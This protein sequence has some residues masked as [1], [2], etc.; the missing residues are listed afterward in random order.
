M[1]EEERK[2]IQLVDPLYEPVIMYPIGRLPFC[3][4]CLVEY[5]ANYMNFKIKHNEEE[6]SSDHYQKT[7]RDYVRKKVKGELETKLK[8]YPWVLEKIDFNR[9]L[10]RQL[11][12]GLFGRLQDEMSNNLVDERMSIPKIA[13]QIKPLGKEEI[14]K[15]LERESK[16][17]TRCINYKY[18]ED[19]VCE[20]PLRLKGEDYTYSFNPDTALKELYD[21]Y[22]ELINTF[23]MQRLMHLQMTGFLSLKYP[24]ST[25]TRF[26]HV[27][28]TWISGLIALQNVT[29]VT[30][31]GEK[32]LIE[33]LVD[34]DMHR[35]FMAA[36][37]LH[38]IGHA[39]FSHV[40][41]MNP[42]LRYNH[43][44]ITEEEIK[45]ANSYLELEDLL[46][47][48]YVDLEF[49]YDEIYG[50]I[51]G[52]LDKVHD[53]IRIKEKFVLVH[54]VIASMGLD[55][56]VIIE[57]FSDE[58][59]KDPAVRALRGL[60]HGVIDID[61]IDHIYRDLHYNGF[62]TMGIPLTSLF[63]GIKIH[64]GEMP[65]IKVSKEITPIIEI[66]LEA[67]E[68]SNKAIFDNP[69][70]NFYIG[71]LNAAISDGVIMMPLLKYYI[72][73]LTDEALLHVL[74]NRDL[75]HNLSPTKKI[76]II[77]G[78]SFGH[79]DY[80]YSSYLIRKWDIARGDGTE[81]K[82][83][84]EMPDKKLKHDILKCIS[85]LP[86]GKDVIWYVFLKDVRRD[87]GLEGKHYPTPEKL[88]IEKLNEDEGKFKWLI[89]SIL[90]A[91]G[92]ETE[93]IKGVL[94]D[95]KN[96]ESVENFKRNI[97]EQTEKENV[98]GLKVIFEESNDSKKLKDK[99]NDLIGVDASTIFFK[100]LSTKVYIDNENN[101]KNK[102]E[103]K[104]KKYIE[105]ITWDG[106][107]KRSW[108]FTLF[109]KEKE[110]KI[111][112]I[113]EKLKNEIIWIV[114]EERFVSPIFENNVE[115]KNELEK[116]KNITFIFFDNTEKD[117][118]VKE[119]KKQNVKDRIKKI[120]HSQSGVKP[121]VFVIEKIVD[122]DR[123]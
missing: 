25:H 95:T 68:L 56:E 77:T 117:E 94:E 9:S 52:I 123:V 84:K 16:D 89:A 28:G 15:L 13:D 32:R 105:G 111:D 6:I 83:K 37:I 119:Q 67:R 101:P 80:R 63:H 51:P 71:V 92:K 55:E 4:S 24:S 85:E 78:S 62:K 41:E 31:K 12:M 113:E 33:F 18:E 11:R 120:A 75:F 73:Y 60:V 88:D 54:D 116:D 44:E 50:I 79:Q 43:E 47:S 98:E 7:F 19:K 97:K 76:G 86:K 121:H 20:N 40:L 99:I 114:E 10:R 1:A 82:V 57:L 81:K 69:V 70:N 21:L 26:A 3:K 58:Y 36:L 87:Y 39:P 30:E 27:I 112:K 35:E 22:N 104:L 109:E 34:E 61:R 64:Y 72:P 103:E 91:E 100:E 23:E 29:V 74:I 106:E 118:K 122:K 108:T 45:G 115:I 96:N 38:D 14:Q 66:L 53:T 90:I 42:H 102:L 46:V 107:E 5:R 49:G 48:S 110:S 8:E 59:S 17:I 65:Y 93:D 2:E